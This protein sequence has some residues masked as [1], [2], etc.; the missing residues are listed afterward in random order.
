MLN[1]TQL[2]MGEPGWGPGQTPKPVTLGEQSYP[3]R[4]CRAEP[5]L[6][7]GDER[8]LAPPAGPLGPCLAWV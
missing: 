4:E 2:A 5:H 3:E 8:E 1:I 7:R 6:S